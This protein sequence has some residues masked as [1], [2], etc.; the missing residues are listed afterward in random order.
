M[1]VLVQ[2]RVSNRRRTSESGRS[3][4]VIF[5]ERGF[6][7]EAK[8]LYC[9]FPSANGLRLE[10]EIL[11]A[12]GRGSFVRGRRLYLTDFLMRMVFVQNMRFFLLSEEDSF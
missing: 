5:F 2:T 6:F 4:F 3:T 9:W 10:F 1:Y 7:V 11:L 12:S 8:R